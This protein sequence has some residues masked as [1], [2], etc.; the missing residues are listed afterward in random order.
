MPPVWKL[1]SDW[2]APFHQRL[3]GLGF[4]FEDRPAQLFL[5]RAK[6]I[7]VNLYASGTVLI[8]GS[9]GD[10]MRKVEAILEEFGGHRTDGSR[11]A[12]DAIEA[13]TGTRIGTDESGKGDYF[14]PLVVAGVLVTPE[15]GEK[16]RAIGVR[17]SKKLSDARIAT[18]APRIREAVGAACFH[19]LAIP[20]EEYN[21]LYDPLQGIG[22]LLGWA[23]AQ[24]IETLLAKGPPCDLS[25][26]DQF[27]DDR[28]IKRH[29]GERGRKLRLLQTP[30][31]ERDLAVAAASVLARD[32]FVRSLHAM[33]E[34]WSVEF[35]KGSSQVVDAGVRFV[36]DH[37]FEALGKVAKV[38][39][40]TTGKIMAESRPR[41]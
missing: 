27:G 10:A 14:G 28:H 9:D 5:A 36:R 35:P 4:S 18:M 16:L 12:P 38:H 26:A 33:G 24:V 29:L 41:V 20:P 6:G 32:V 22:A 31:G 1:S 8:N 40:T 21:R 2:F 37:G 23:H 39:F 3:E 13:V 30:K 7:S 11:P 34:K 15:A 19:E 25:V 17:D